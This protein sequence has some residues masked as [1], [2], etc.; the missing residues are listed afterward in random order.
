[1]QW[2]GCAR[3]PPLDGQERGGDHLWLPFVQEL[4]EEIDKGRIVLGAVV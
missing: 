1:M 4:E 2:L 3:R